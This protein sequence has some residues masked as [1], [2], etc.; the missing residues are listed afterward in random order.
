MK[1]K[2]FRKQSNN[3]VAAR[4]KVSE[5]ERSTLYFVDLLLQDMRNIGEKKMVNAWCITRQSGRIFGLGPNSLPQVFATREEARAALRRLRGRGIDSNLKIVRA[6]EV[7]HTA[8]GV[9]REGKIIGNGV[10]SVPM[11]FK[12]REQA[13]EGVR[14]AESVGYTGATVIRFGLPTQATDTSNV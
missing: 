1:R 2:R 8:W 9:A 7:S 4:F 3:V 13:R 11:V 12:T 10:T 6:E 14:F 5:E